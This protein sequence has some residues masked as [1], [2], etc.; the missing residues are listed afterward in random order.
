LGDLSL[1]DAGLAF[2]KQRPP[3][4][5]SEKEHGR[6][7]AV[8]E[9]IGRRQQIERGINRVGQRTWRRCHDAELIAG[10]RRAC[11]AKNA[12]VERV[13]GSR[14]AAGGLPAPPNPPPPAP[15]R[16]A[17]TPMRC[18][19]YSALPWMSLAIPSAGTVIPSSDFGPKRF[20]SASS[21]AVTRNTPLEPAP[22]TAPRISEPRFDAN[23]PTSA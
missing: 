18:A 22:V 9:I 12:D 2:E 4:F 19:R 15:A 7:R 17:K 20:L 23:T 16:R 14:S 5:E 11:P 21:N 3:H 1:A 13:Q 8:G 6:E 10:Q